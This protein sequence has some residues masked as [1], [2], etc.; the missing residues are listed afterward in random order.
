MLNSQHNT[1]SGSNRFRLPL[2]I[3]TRKHRQRV[4]YTEKPGADGIVQPLTGG[5]KN[6]DYPLFA[7][8]PCASWAS[9]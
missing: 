6:P 4:L 8:K 2:A 9:W 5:V 7:V 3:S 1:E